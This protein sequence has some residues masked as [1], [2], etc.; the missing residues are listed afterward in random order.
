MLQILTFFCSSSSVWVDAILLA[1]ALKDLCAATSKSCTALWCALQMTLPRPERLDHDAG[2][3]ATSA[4]SS[5]DKFS[6]SYTL[7]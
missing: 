1:V 5:S 4:K 6:Y 7:A 3:E 2:R